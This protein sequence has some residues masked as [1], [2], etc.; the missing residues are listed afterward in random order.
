MYQ[1]PLPT[2]SVKLGPARHSGIVQVGLGAPFLSL[3]RQCICYLQ[4]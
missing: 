2:Y 3:N 1:L 4:P